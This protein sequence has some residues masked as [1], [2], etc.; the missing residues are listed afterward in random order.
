LE[1]LEGGL[2]RAYGARLLELLDCNIGI[3]KGSGTET[4]DKGGFEFLPGVA[5]PFSFIALVPS[6]RLILELHGSDG[7]LV[8]GRG[9]VVSKIFLELK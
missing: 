5:W 6:V 9:A 3:L 2:V 4:A 7:N 8:L 1:I